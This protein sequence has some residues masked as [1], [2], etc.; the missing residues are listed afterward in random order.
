MTHEREY[1]VRRTVRAYADLW[2][3]AQALLARAEKEPEG[4]YWLTMSS[5]L[6]SAF[7]FEAYLNHMG[8]ARIKF[9]KEIES[10]RVFEK[11]SVLCKE[12]DYDAD[13]SRRPCQTLKALI[14]FRNAIAHGKSEILEETD[15]STAEEP[16]P[17]TSPKTSWEEYCIREHALRALED[18]SSIMRALDR[19]AGLPE[20]PFRVISSTSGFSYP[21]NPSQEHQNGE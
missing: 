18:V 14:R 1:T 11:F 19:K 9:W 21:A 20:L 5:L 12:L 8:E 6:L 4:A 15:M 16:F 17:K 7:T 10:I 13:F 2:A 3:G